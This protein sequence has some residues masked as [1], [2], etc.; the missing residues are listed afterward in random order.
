MKSEGMDALKKSEAWH[1]ATRIEQQLPYE[2]VVSIRN[3][4]GLDDIAGAERIVPYPSALYGLGDAMGIPLPE[5]SVPF[6]EG[7]TGL[8][9]D[10]LA[11]G[12]V[13]IKR[14]AEKSPAAVKKCEAGI[15]AGQSG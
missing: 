9:F 8:L 4:L 11:S 12:D 3:R 15:A 6:P 14:C 1:N 2:V 13:A 5:I 10:I 7:P